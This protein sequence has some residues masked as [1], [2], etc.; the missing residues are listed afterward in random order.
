MVNGV[1]RLNFLF[2]MIYN[3]VY[4]NSKN[5]VKIILQIKLSFICICINLLIL[6]SEINEIIISENN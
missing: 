1:N 2:N 4:E 5:I 3:Y 6:I